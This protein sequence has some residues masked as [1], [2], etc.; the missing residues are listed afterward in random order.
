MKYKL[1]FCIPTLNY[2][3]FIGET[4]KSIITQADE[5]V[6]IVIVDGGSTDETAAIVSEAT[7]HFPHIKFIQRGQRLGID[8]DILESVVQA[9]G[10]YCW[11]FSSDDI[12]LPGA[13]TRAMKAVDEGEWDV[14]LMGV[15]LCD[16]NMRPLHNHP[17]LSC[18]ES[19]SFHWSDSAQRA[20][21]F[22]RAQ[23][24]TAFFSF[25]SDIIVRRDR[26]LGVPVMDRFVGSCWIIAVQLFAMSE[27]PPGL[28]VRFDPHIYLLKRG[29]NDSF[30]AKGLISRIR[31]SIDGFRG[32]GRHFF[33]EDSFE[34]R[35]ISRVVSNEYPLVE[36]LSLK[37]RLFP[38]RTLQ[39]SDE[40]YSLAR[41]HFA[42]QGW[43]G[44]A[45]YLLLRL[46]PRWIMVPFRPAFRLVVAIGRNF[47]L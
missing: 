14:F 1:S 45:K 21:Y 29:D 41:S 6:Q 13:I 23:T 7:I 24:S 2:G 26:W 9:D 39:N 12:L 4:L 10:D 8:R 36:M 3:S 31:L 17:I 47:N 28:L 11:L 27:T 34:A 38:S 42:H 32:I 46:A 22:S 30:A 37:C 20:D 15:A 35:Q 33:G 44:Y 25:I 19:R 5:S 43:R 40:F 18:K 16:L